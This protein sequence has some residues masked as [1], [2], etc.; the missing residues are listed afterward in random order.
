ML[1]IERK[2]QD[3]IGFEYAKIIEFKRKEIKY[4]TKEDAMEIRLTRKKGKVIRN[5][6]SE[7]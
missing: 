4:L 3:V 2:K 6:I 1:I 7:M 5:E